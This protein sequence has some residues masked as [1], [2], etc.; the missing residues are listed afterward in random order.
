MKRSCAG[1]TA[2]GRL[3]WA[4]TARIVPQKARPLGGEDVLYEAL[5]LLSLDE[6]DESCLLEALRKVIVQSLLAEVEVG[7]RS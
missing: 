6:A 3:G 2:P 7:A 4:P 1:G 5:L